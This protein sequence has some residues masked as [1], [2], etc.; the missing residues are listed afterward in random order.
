MKSNWKKGRGKLGRFRPLLGK[1]IAES[2]S[3]MGPVRCTREFKAILAGSYIQLEANWEFLA[4]PAFDQCAEA[5]EMKSYRELAVIGV[6]DKGEICFWSF[7]SDGK[8]SQGM[9]TD[10]TD[11]HPEAI[12]F[13]A[14][15]PAGTARMAYW[16]DSSNGFHWV[17]EFQTKTGWSRMLSHHYVAEVK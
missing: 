8:R 1:W 3:P 2:E 5:T 17:V 10:V 7:T 14:K 13:I 12:G 4:K 16:P 6:E 15:M 9:V 11:L